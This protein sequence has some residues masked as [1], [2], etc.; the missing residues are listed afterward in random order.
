MKLRWAILIVAVTAFAIPALAGSTATGRVTGKIVYTSLK[1]GQAD[2]YSMNATGI[3][4]VNLTHDK[5]I[6]VRSD[7]QPVWSPNGGWVAV[8][9]QYA[10]A[11]AELMVVRADGTRLHP[12]LPTLSKG[13]WSCHPSW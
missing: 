9:R 5:T 2:V 13:V 7:V 8:D 11:G 10:K 4:V 12:L 6:G 3:N 1:D